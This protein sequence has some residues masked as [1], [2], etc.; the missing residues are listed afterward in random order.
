MCAWLLLTPS[1]LCA[2]C[3]DH[4]RLPVLESDLREQ[5]EATLL[6]IKNS[7]C[8]LLLTETHR[9]EGEHS[10]T[11][12]YTHTHTHIGQKRG[13][14]ERQHALLEITSSSSVDLATPY[15]C[16]HQD[17]AM[18]TAGHFILTNSLIRS[19]PQISAALSFY[20]GEKSAA[21]SAVWPT[22]CLSVRVAV[23]TSADMNN[24]VS[25]FTRHQVYIISCRRAIKSSSFRLNAQLTP[26]SCSSLDMWVIEQTASESIKVGSHSTVAEIKKK[27]YW[28][29]GLNCQT[30]KDSNPVSE[31]F[32]HLYTVL[33]RSGF[34]R[35]HLTDTIS[36][37][38]FVFPTAPFA[39]TVGSAR[40]VDCS[41]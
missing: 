41:K 22:L 3:H 27:S 33:N 37:Q 31:L 4:E 17:V 10:H 12:L 32:P 28:S 6:L 38:L 2:C 5:R 18:I 13:G 1:C 26:S 29:R 9:H 40:P 30:C 25:A 14:G 7:S 39:V 11:C 34:G 23:R 20:P 35:S 19:D 24:R 36:L 21:S 8:S 15:P 16:L